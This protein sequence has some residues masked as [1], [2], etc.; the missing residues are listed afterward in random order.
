MSSLLLTLVWA[1]D[2]WLRE[3]AG[4]TLDDKAEEEEVGGEDSAGTKRPAE[5]TESV[6]TCIQ[7]YNLT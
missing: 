2:T 1:D 3:H 4:A 7:L 6:C 5:E